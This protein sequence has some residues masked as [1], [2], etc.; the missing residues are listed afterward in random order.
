MNS[1]LE[2]AGPSTWLLCFG[3]E[4]MKASSGQRDSMTR[5]LGCMPLNPKLANGDFRFSLTLDDPNL[6]EYRFVRY[7]FSFDWLRDDGEGCRITDETIEIGS[8]QRGPW[9]N[10][11]KRAEGKSRRASIRA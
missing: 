1:H 10:Y 5:A 11:L 3:F 7:G 9:T 2:H 4:F 8:K 6:G